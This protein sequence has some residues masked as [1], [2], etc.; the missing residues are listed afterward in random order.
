M[1]VIVEQ[2]NGSKTIF[3]KGAAEKMFKICQKNSLPSDFEKQVDNYSKA[4]YRTIGFGFKEYSGNVENPERPTIECDLQ[5]LG[6]AF[7]ENP[8]KKDSMH[9]IRELNA[10]RIRPIMVTGDNIQTA[11]QI[12]FQTEILTHQNQ[13]CII[14]NENN[15]LQLESFVPSTDEQKY[16]ISKDPTIGQQPQTN[17][18]A[19]IAIE[20]PELVKPSEVQA[21]D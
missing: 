19:Q 21:N 20:L 16:R 10:V 6:L 12:A 8:V 18:G 15:R 13:I 9:V 11:I 7:F 14:K 1:S 5:F 2:P 17:Q 3:T 4:G